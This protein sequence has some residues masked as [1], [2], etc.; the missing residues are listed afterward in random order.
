MSRFCL[1]KYLLYHLQ[2][3]AHATALWCGLAG[4]GLLQDRQDVAAL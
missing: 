3:M 2:H 4:F 1:A